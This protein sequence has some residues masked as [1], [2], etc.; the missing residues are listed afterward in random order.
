MSEVKTLAQ[1]VREIMAFNIGVD[2]SLVKEE[3]RPTTDLKADS[4]ELVEPAMA[5]EDEFNIVI[6][7]DEVPDGASLTVGEWIALVERKVEAKHAAR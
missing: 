2:L 4:L 6:D 7:D 5:L 3:T 1:R